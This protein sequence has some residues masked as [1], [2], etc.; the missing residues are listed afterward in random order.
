MLPI[1]F[2]KRWFP[3]LFDLLFDKMASINKFILIRMANTLQQP[4]RTEMIS[5]FMVF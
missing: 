1:A 3:V 5:D 2:K 4:Y